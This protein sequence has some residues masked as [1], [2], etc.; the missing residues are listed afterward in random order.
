MKTRRGGLRW[1]MPAKSLTTSGLDTEKI[2][3]SCRCSWFIAER[4][5]SHERTGTSLVP[6]TMTSGVL[7]LL[8]ASVNN[9]GTLSIVKYIES[10]SVASYVLHGINN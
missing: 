2:D 4:G 3:L 6:A 5:T 7:Y 10:A 8:S 1:N 9:E